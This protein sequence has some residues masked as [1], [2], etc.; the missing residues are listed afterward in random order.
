MN[1]GLNA[2]RQVGTSSAVQD[3]DPHRLVQMLLRGAMDSL[4][5]AEGHLSNSDIPSKAQQ[6]SRAAGIIEALRGSLDFSAGELSNNLDALYEYMLSR[7]A[8]ANATNDAEGIREVAALLEPIRSAWDEIR[9]QVQA[10]LSERAGA[11]KPP[12]GVHV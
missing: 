4:R 8:T 10:Q 6:L 11:S 2:Y 3:A 7:L 12:P 1:S 5:A 9:P